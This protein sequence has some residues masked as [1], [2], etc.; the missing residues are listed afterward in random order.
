[1]S[2]EQAERF[3]AQKLRTEKQA[4]YEEAERLQGRAAGYQTTQP[5]GMECGE[6]NAKPYRPP[7]ILERIGK[8]LNAHQQESRRVVKLEALRQ[9][10]EAHPEVARIL[11]LKAEL[12]Y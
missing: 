6:M 4:L 10:L 9:L 11:E 5:M 12:G 3:E 8:E 1:M 7:S 2:N